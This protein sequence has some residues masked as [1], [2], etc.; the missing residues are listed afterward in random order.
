M[1]YVLEMKNITKIFPG[2]IAND[3]ISLN[4]KKGE[5]HA[6][7]VKTELGNLL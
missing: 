5:I 4:L 2:T 3:D 7:W 6:F 1:E